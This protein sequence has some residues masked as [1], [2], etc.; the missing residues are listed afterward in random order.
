MRR[1]AELSRRWPEAEGW[2]RADTDRYRFSNKYHRGTDCLLGIPSRLQW[3]GCGHKSNIDSAAGGKGFGEEEG[4][5]ADGGKEEGQ[6]VGGTELGE[7]HSRVNSSCQ[8]LCPSPLTG[9]I[10]RWDNCRGFESSVLEARRWCVGVG[11]PGSHLLRGAA[12]PPLS[13]PPPEAS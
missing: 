7:A 2:C 3:G 13:L 4:A 8:C 5:G 1:E 12:P 6:T 10:Y 9:C 11:R